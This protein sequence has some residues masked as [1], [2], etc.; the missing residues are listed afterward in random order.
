MARS[1]S[2]SATRRSWLSQRR[3][4][5][6]RRRAFHHRSGLHGLPDE[7]SA[8][9]HSTNLIERL[10]SEIKRRTER[11]RHLSNKAVVVRFVGALLLKQSDE[12]ATQRSR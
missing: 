12:W 1:A 6:I 11:G 4:D 10:N 8:K 2:A 3:P 7:H 9:L 5:A